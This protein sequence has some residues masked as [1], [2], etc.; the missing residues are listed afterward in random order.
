L[1]FFAVAAILWRYG[2]PLR[3]FVENHLGKVTAAFAVL[4]VGGFA[5]IRLLR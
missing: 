1:R 4:L 2:E 3:A 5:L